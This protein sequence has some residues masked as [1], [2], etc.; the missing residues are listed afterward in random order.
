MNDLFQRGSPRDKRGEI[1][2]LVVALI[3]ILAASAVWHLSRP[4]A[5]SW[6]ARSSLGCQPRSRIIAAALRPKFETVPV[7]HEY[8]NASGLPYRGLSLWSWWRPERGWIMWES[9]RHRERTAGGG[10]LDH[11]KITLVDHK[12]D[13]LGEAGVNRTVIVAQPGDRDGDGRWELV[14]ELSAT[15]WQ[16]YPNR[17]V[18][19]WAVIRLG[20]DHNEIAWIGLSDHLFWSQKSTRIKPIWRDEDGDGVKELVFVTVVFKR[21]PQ[22]GVGFD[23]PSTVAVFEWDRSGGVLQPRSLPEDAGIISWTPFQSEP[24]RAEIDADIESL[25]AKLLPLP[26]GFGVHPAP[27]PANSPST[28]SDSQ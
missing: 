14:F 25:L 10:W 6:I 4:A 8:L 23:P 28:P 18:Q 9:V 3:T 20:D 24:V 5:I 27:P 19:R 13:L 1:R 17:D 21:L 11:L 16:D 7:Q 15:P 2:R 26:E 12:F 22:G